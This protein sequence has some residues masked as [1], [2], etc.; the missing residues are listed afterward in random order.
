MGDHFIQLG[1]WRWAAIDH[2]HFSV[3][4]KDG[5]TAQIYRN[6]GTVHPGPRTD[7]NAWGR[8]IGPAKGISFGFQYIQIGRFRIGAVNDAHF[9]I[10]H[11][12]GQ[13]IQI[14]RNDGTLHPGP[15]TDYSTFDRPEGAAS[16]ISFGD[17]FI[18]IGKFRIGDADGWHAL[19]THS[20][21]QTA[22]I[23]RGDGTLH[24]G[25]RTDWTSAIAN[26][27]P[28]PWTCRSLEESQPNSVKM[29][30]NQSERPTVQIARGTPKI[31]S[32]RLTCTIC[33][34]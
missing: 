20:G 32:Q 27:L 10:S 5:Y 21:G 24:P 2:N 3:S 6:D 7:Y 9:S 29:K 18:Q 15:R 17:K 34:L 12:D 22:Q 25:P 23:Y 33:Q 31:Q 4:H 16:G 13:T 8:S 30:L 14:F 28:V 26:R 11:R 19:V 1:D